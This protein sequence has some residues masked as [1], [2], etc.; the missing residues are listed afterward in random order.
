MKC[1]LV[2]FHDL[3]KI[4]PTDGHGT[5]IKYIYHHHNYKYMLFYLNQ[6]F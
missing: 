3:I 5:F 2:I 4:V 6:K 1:Y